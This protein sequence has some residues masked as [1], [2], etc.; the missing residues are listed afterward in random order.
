MSAPAAIASASPS[1]TIFA[2][3][4]GDTSHPFGQLAAGGSAG[5]KIDFAGDRDWF[6]I[7]LT[8]GQ[9]AAV[10]LQGG[11]GG[12]TLADPYLRLEDANGAELAVNDNAATGNPT[13]SS[14]TRRRSPPPTI[15]WR[16][17]PATP[18]PAATS[19]ASPP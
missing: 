16:V 5:G 12:G 15:W 11:H 17:R 19:S 2:S 9:V 1:S 18:A 13:R 14:F 7:Q 6:K 4:L 3:S 8:A 10:N